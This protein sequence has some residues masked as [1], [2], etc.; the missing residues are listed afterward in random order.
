MLT[1]KN[2]RNEGVANN[3]KFEQTQSRL[4]S[5]EKAKVTVNVQP[6]GFFS[7]THRVDIKDMSVSVTQ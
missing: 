7:L 1:K 2:H 5:G 6:E 4:A 3:K